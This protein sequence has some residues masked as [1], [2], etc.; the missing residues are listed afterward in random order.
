MSKK[1]YFARTKG[2]LFLIMIVCILVGC[3]EKISSQETHNTNEIP[4]SSE[5]KSFPSATATPTEE[6]L[7]KRTHDLDRPDTVRAADA[8][9]ATQNAGRPTTTP[10]PSPTPTLSAKQLCQPFPDSIQYLGSTQT[11]GFP[12]W[13]IRGRCHGDVTY[14]RSP[15]GDMTLYDYTPLTGRFSF[16]SPDSAGNEAKIGPPPEVFFIHAKINS[17]SDQELGVDFMWT[18]SWATS[19][20]GHQF[21]QV[22]VT[23]QTQIVDINGDLTTLDAIKSGMTI[24][25]TARKLSPYTLSLFAYKIQVYCDQ[26]PY[27]LGFEARS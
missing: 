6:I 15:V 13:T 12:A 14:Y 16:G 20:Y 11:L 8:A 26:T 4:T 1:A 19:R 17:I 18:N 2:M 24:E 9:D 22:M 3:A 25:L 23:D 27:Y 7:P 5:Q 21:T 10:K